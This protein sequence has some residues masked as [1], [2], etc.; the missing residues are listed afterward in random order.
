MDQKTVANIFENLP[1]DLALS[2]ER[3]ALRNWL[4]KQ[5]RIME[6]LARVSLFVLVLDVA[7]FAA[8]GFQRLEFLM[9]I[10]FCMLGYLFSRSRTQKLDM[11]T[12]THLEHFV[13]TVKREKAV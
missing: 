13:E 4:G 8:T 9:I 6:W 7:G 1:D 10:G 12:D 5:R 2:P 3:E 11:I